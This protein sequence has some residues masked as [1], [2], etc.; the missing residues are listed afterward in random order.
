[1]N[2]SYGD[3]LACA[4]REV[5]FRERVYPRLVQQEKMTPIKAAN[6]IAAMK[7]IVETLRPL[8]AREELPL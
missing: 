4:E 2:I 7:A 3:Q 1:M 5:R 6:E 8:A